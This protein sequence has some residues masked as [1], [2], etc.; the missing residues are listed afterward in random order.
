MDAAR[1]LKVRNSL[2]AASRPTPLTT[3][4][5]WLERENGR[6]VQENESLR[7]RCADLGASAELWIGL[8]EAALA[9]LGRTTRSKT[10]ERH[11]AGTVETSRHHAPE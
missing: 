6:L 3:S 8:Y 7:Q 1:S 4:R 9:R 2:P 5:Q 11:V 10:V